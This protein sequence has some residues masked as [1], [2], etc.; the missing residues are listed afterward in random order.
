MEYWRNVI[1]GTPR[2]ATTKGLLIHMADECGN[3]PGPDYRFG[4]GMINVADAARL[5]S[6][7]GM[8]GCQQY[9]EG[10]LEAGETF[11][12]NIH[13]MGMWPL[14]ATLSWND[15]AANNTNNSAVNPAGVRYLVNDLDLRVDHNGST[16]L[17]WTLDP[18]NPAAAATTGDNDRDNVEQVLLLSPQNG[19]YTLRVVAPGAL[20]DGPQRFTLWFS[21]NDA[22]DLDRTVSGVVL[23]STQT[24]AVQQDLSFGPAVNVVSPAK[25]NAY[26]G[27]AVRL[28]PGFHAQSGAMFH[29]RI[30]PGGGC[31][32]MSGSLKTDNYPGSGFDEPIGDLR[33]SEDQNLT[34]EHTSTFT[35]MPNPATD[36]IR[37]AFQTV[38][39][40][41]VSIWLTDQQGRIV[42]TLQNSTIL[43]P[44]EHTLPFELSA[45]SAG[46]YYCILQ[47][48]NE[49]ETAPLLIHRL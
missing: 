28:V 14:K 25:I 27:H 24:F 20:T 41:R 42:Q 21:G 23:N 35:I 19:T 44:G 29:A 9:V 18:N 48:G 8:D 7:E 45:L 17:P 6:I 15:P 36:V 40:Q 33:S 34:L 47:K 5:I 16:F 37:I 12:I 22:M 26:A 38:Q 46:I 31:G 2:A 3:N 49:Q 39:N 10:S 4:W 11:A 13:S 43:E 1:G 30:L 32:L